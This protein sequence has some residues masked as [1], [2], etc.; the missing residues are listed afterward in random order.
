MPATTNKA[1]VS[2]GKWRASTR[3]WCS[4]RSTI[5]T[6]SSTRCAS[7]TS[8]A[9][10]STK[11]CFQGRSFLP[12]TELLQD[13]LLELQHGLRILELFR[14]YQQHVLGAVAERVDARRLQVD[15]VARQD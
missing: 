1:G 4:T 3:A 13:V 10:D 6:A 7:G 9:S 15:A 5:S 2:N 12:K 8:R 14:S 11:S